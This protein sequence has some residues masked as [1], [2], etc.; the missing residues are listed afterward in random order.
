ME[1][2]LS[3]I[4]AS[5][6]TISQSNQAY[7][8]YDI[9]AKPTKRSPSLNKYL[10]V[11]S[12][13]AIAKKFWNVPKRC[14]L[15]LFVTTWDLKQAFFKYQNQQKW[16]DLDLIHEIWLEQRWWNT[17]ETGLWF[18]HIFDCKMIHRFWQCSHQQFCL[19]LYLYLYHQTSLGAVSTRL[20]SG[21]IRFQAKYIC[22]W[23]AW[24]KRQ[25]VVCKGVQVKVIKIFDETAFKL[26]KLHFN[27]TEL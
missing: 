3:F 9:P 24:Q 8:V 4:Q 15:K 7:I 5:T 23:C 6:K 26:L 14:W 11:G 25:C 22:C 21:S 16:G 1:Q 27:V 18:S 2:V 20:A 17:G 12:W 19:D 13:S 10:E